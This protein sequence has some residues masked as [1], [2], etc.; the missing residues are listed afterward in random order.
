MNKYHKELNDRELLV[1]DLRVVL[2]KTLK[3]TGDHIGVGK[4]RARE[5]EQQTLRK[6]DWL[7][8]N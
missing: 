5:I 1:L 6:L 2:G 7:R 3:E 4:A 8:R